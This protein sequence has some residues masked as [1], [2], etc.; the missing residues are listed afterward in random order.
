MNKGIKIENPIYP[1]FAVAFRGDPDKALKFFK[2]H[3]PDQSDID[4]IVNEL[5]LDYR[6][7]TYYNPD[8]NVFIHFNESATSGS[9]AHECFHATETHM[10][11]IGQPYS[12]EASEAWAYYLGF[13]VN[14]VVNGL[15][16]E[17][18]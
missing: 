16:N 12:E 6:A 13:L 17:K 14:A 3:F 5:G 11:T 8:G 10:N 18:T 15:Y 7:K 9:I 1:K 4:F 2:K